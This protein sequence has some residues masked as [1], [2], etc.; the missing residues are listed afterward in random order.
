MSFVRT[1]VFAATTPF[2][3]A[4]ACDVPGGPGPGADGAAFITVT[5]AD[6]ELNLEHDPLQSQLSLTPPAEGTVQLTFTFQD[7]AV[8][9]RLTVDDA[10][11]DEGDTVDLPGDGVV[12]TLDVDGIDYEATAGS[13]TI[14]VLAIDEEAGT[15]AASIDADLTAADDAVVTVVGDVEA[16]SQ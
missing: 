13:V 10:L 12:L 7:P 11:V 5:T 9:L 15:L 4:A 16:S 3:A 2:L 1:V 8:E 14:N 6:E